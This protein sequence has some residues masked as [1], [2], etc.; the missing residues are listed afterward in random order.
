M[1]VDINLQL[2]QKYRY[3]AAAALDKNRL[4][5]YRFYSTLEKYYGIKHEEEFVG[6][7]S[8]LLKRIWWAIKH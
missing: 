3:K 6:T 7:N 5:K 1:P 2:E 8:G 4:L